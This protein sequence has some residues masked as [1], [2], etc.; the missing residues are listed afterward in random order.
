[1]KR[2]IALTRAEDQGRREQVDAMLRDN[3]LEEVGRF[4]ASHC[5]SQNLG[6]LP[7]QTPP[8]WYLSAAVAVPFEAHGCEATELLKNCS[9]RGSAG[10]SRIRC[11]RSMRLSGQTRSCSHDL[12]RRR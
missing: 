1:M 12:A 3:S 10:T 9:M 6:L 5:Q 8:L 11:R 7:W 2:A 4:C